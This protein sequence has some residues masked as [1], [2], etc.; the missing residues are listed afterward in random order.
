MSKVWLL[1]TKTYRHYLR[2]GTFLILTFGLP[3]LMIIA[4]AVPIISMSRDGAAALG[5]VDQTGRLGLA[6]APEG[7][8]V[9]DSPA[10]AETALAHN[11]IEGYLVVPATYFDGERPTYHSAEE[12]GIARQQ[13]LT[14]LMR[15]AMLTD[16]PAWLL[17][18]LETPS[19]ITYVARD[20]GERVTAG[21]GLIVQIVTPLALAILFGLVVLTGVGQMGLAVIQEKEQRSM[22]MVITSLAPWQLV[23]GKVL[24]ITLLTMTQIGIWATAGAIGLGL[25]WNAYGA[26]QPFTLPWT[27][28]LWAAL[29]GIPA[30]FLYAVI[31]AGLG[32]IAGGRQQ[33]RQ[34]AGLLGFIGLLPLYF[35]GMLINALD[36]PLALGL[37]WFPLTAP[38]IALF[39]LALSQV[40]L[41]QLLVSLA[42]LLLCLIGAVWVVARIFRAAMLM[43]GQAL[44]P[45]QIWLALRRA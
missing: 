23:T 26:G 41:W 10:A 36:G 17:E 40:P 15:Q 33:A 28:I 32:I 13:S 39:R 21:F 45:R 14:R 1:A 20:T 4:G 29:L 3:L 9:Y 12:P 30:Y 18:R 34:L 7:V 42:I 8:T 24:G 19:E 16:Q 25:A 27:A 5:Y 2:S 38:M 31:A 44:R 37:T 43:Y 6:P 22:E 35:L 11:Q